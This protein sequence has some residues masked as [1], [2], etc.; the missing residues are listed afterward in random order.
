VCVR[1]GGGGGG[2]EGGL[3]GGGGHGGQPGLVGVAFDLECLLA[4]CVG[5]GGIGD[6]EQRLDGVELGGRVRTLEGGA[7]LGKVDL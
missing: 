4:L 2:R 7:N 6:T 1:L 5:V 3:G